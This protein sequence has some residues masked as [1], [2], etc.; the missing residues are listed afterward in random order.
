MAIKIL[1]NQI[2]Q[3]I[4][5]ETKQVENKET[6]SV[7]AYWVKEPRIIG[8]TRS[9]ED[10]SVSVNFNSYCLVSD[11]SEFSIKESAIVAILEPREDVAQSY[12][13]KVFNEPS[14][15]GPEDGTNS[16]DSDGSTG[17]RTE[18]TPETPNAGGGTD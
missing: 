18:S 3:H 2:G 11:E 8:Y 5:A 12:T 4:I 17:V 6:G 1:V 16:D 9:D 13:A 15:D 7:I 14:T 10:G